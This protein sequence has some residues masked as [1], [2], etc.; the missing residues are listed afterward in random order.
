[1]IN[2]CP[3]HLCHLAPMSLTKLCIFNTSTSQNSLSIGSSHSK[4][5]D[6]SVITYYFY[7]GTFRVNFIAGCHRN[8]ITEK[9]R[10]KAF[11]VGTLALKWT[12]RKDMHTA[13]GL[14]GRVLSV[15]VLHTY[16]T[17]SACQRV[18]SWNTSPWFQCNACFIYWHRC[19]CDEW[20]ACA[21]AL[22]SSSS[23]RGNVWFS[24]Q[25]RIW[26]CDRDKGRFN[27]GFSS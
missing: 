1:M 16:G 18:Q 8:M 21:A 10:Q 23:V 4:A 26:C 27:R 15:C 22:F 5:L 19:G 24:N 7:A 12:K 17:I 20:R 3:E 25:M 11:S 6:S 13:F 2:I 9:N 14:M